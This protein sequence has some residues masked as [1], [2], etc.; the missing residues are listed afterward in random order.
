[1]GLFGS[2]PL[3]P[4]ESVPDVVAKNQDGTEVRLSDFRGRKNVV[5]FF[6]PRDNTPVCT[7]EAC[8]FRDR[9][10]GIQAADA[11]VFGVSSD[12][13][14]SHAAFREAHGMPFD[15]LSDPDGDLRRAFRVPSTMGVLPGRVTFV[16]DKTGVV[17]HV[18]NSQLSAQKHVDEA[19]AALAD[20]G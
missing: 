15:L 4:G 13:E 2:K 10:D 7:Q 9:Y 18:T 14:A 6:Y 1:M 12:S 19:L 20:I 11:A 8:L 3:T 5:V 17:R 16:I